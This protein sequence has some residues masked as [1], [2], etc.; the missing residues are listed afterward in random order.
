MN[1]LRAEI[2]STI[3]QPMVHYSGTR[4]QLQ[5]KQGTPHQTHLTSLQS[6][7]EITKNHSNSPKSLRVSAELNYVNQFKYYFRPEKSA[8]M[9]IKFNP[10]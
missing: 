10:A 2:T 4:K 5:V 1:I 3:E 8:K 9:V 7:W 6:V